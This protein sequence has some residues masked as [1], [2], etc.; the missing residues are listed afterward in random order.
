MSKRA[1]SLLALVLAPVLASAEEAKPPP[2]PKWYDTIEIHGLVDTYYQANLSA[3]Q[4]DPNPLRAFDTANGFQLAYGKLTA[5]MNPAPVGF[6]LDLGFGPVAGILNGHAAT[7]DQAYGP[8]SLGQV[9][10]EQAYVTFKL[11]DVLVDGG[12][13]VTSTG[14]EVIE[15]KDDWLYSRSLLFGWAIPFTHTGLR[16]TTPLGVEGLTLALMIVNGWD[17]PPGPV[18]ALKTGMATLAYAGPASTTLALSVLYGQD[19]GATE[20]KL[21]LDAVVGRAF[22]DLAVNVNGDYGK[23]GDAK[24]Y[25]VSGMLRLSL[26]GDKARVSVRGEWFDDPQG[27]RVGIPD[28]SYYEGTLGLSVPVGGNAELRAEGRYDHSE[29]ALFKGGASNGQTTATVAML[30]WF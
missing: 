28:N 11:G 5:L 2:P 19:P 10:P 3:Q 12:R 27:F 16:V 22:G 1:W 7:Y 17:N 9:T 4:Q 21:L 26:A 18:S 24:W 20:R 23:Q 8:G 29:K 25:G 6:R 13:F 14:A 30:A 15:A